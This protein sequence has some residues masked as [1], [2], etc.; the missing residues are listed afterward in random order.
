MNESPDEPRIEQ[1]EAPVEDAQER[2]PRFGLLLIVL[3]LAVLM[4]V[5]ITVGSEAYFTPK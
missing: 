1:T 5:A 2:G 4:M 3:V